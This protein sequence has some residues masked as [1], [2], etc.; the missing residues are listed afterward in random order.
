M[1]S[2]PYRVG[3][4]NEGNPPYQLARA[5]LP[6]VLSVCQGAQVLLLQRLLRPGWEILQ[7]LAVE[8]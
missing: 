4:G 3:L 7:L 1:G 6:R 5:V 2:C 8:N